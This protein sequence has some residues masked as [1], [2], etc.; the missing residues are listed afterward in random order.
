[1]PVKSSTR[2]RKIGREQDVLGLIAQ[3]V[4]VGPTPLAFLP[5]R[6][7]E[8]WLVKFPIAGG[9]LEILGSTNYSGGLSFPI[10]AAGA[11]YLMEVG[12]SISIDGPASFYMA[13]AGATSI[14]HVLRTLTSGYNTQI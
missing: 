9:T 10:A 2:R 3:R 8:G 11:G 4:S 5:I 14:V 13:S 7:Q 12:E 6:G 1:M